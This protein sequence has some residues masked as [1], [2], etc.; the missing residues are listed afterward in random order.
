MAKQDLRGK[1]KFADNDWLAY[2]APMSFELAGREL[3]LGAA[4]EEQTVLT[5]ADAPA[6][7]L[8]I[9]GSTA[10]YDCVKISEE[11]YIVIR[12]GG[13][14]GDVSVFDLGSGRYIR[15]VPG[16]GEFAVRLSVFGGV[17][18]AKAAWTDVE[19]ERVAPDFAGNTVEYVPGMNAAYIVT[20]GADG[21][22]ALD[23]P[24]AAVSDFEAYRVAEGVYFQTARVKKG[25]NTYSVCAVTN[26]RSD[27]FGGA[28]FT[29]DG[30]QKIGG[31]C[32]SKNA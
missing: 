28:V 12:G 17:K 32:R 16:G 24:G 15:W 25:R 13:G 11:I 18:D 23:I 2:A 1:Y 27:M 3:I 31:Y 30:A 29:K 26:Y 10:E 4:T 14:T 5:F 21:K 20:Y 9:G 22:A 8:T 6:R 19:S 7:T